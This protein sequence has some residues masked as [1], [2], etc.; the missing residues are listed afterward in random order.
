MEDRAFA[1]QAATLYTTYHLV[2]IIIYRPFIRVPRGRSLSRSHSAQRSSFSQKAL[3]ICLTAARAG[4]H[5]LEIQ[6]R[7]GMLN[8][9]NVI[10]VSFVCAG[11]LLV[12]LWD[13]IRQFGMSRGVVSPEGRAQM[14]QEISSV[15]GEIGDIMARLEEV[16]SKWELA[17][18]ML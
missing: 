12:H 9:T 3:S 1:S 18:E 5:I 14:S 13:L 7:R 16:S 17:R 10:H 6:T 11:V 2:Q 8:I 15:M 4:A